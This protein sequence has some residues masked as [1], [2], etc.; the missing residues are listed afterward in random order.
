[1]SDG[2]ITGSPEEAPEG[3][4]GQVRPRLPGFRPRACPHRNSCTSSRSIRS[5]W[6]CRTRSCSAPRPIS[7]TPGI[8]TCDLY[9]FAPVG[10]LTVDASGRIEDANLTSA[11]LLGIDRGK[12]RG[13]RFAALV[14]PESVAAWGRLLSE[15]RGDDEPRSCDLAVRRGGGPV[16]AAQVS[17]QRRGADPVAGSMRV[18][19]TDISR[20]KRAE[21]ALRDGEERMRSIVTSMAEGV[22]VQ[23]S[24]GRVLTCNPA[25]ERILGLSSAQIE[26]RTS[27]D[28][29]WRAIHEDGSPF[30]G[31]EHPA[32]RTLSNGVPLANVLMGVHRP[33]G[34]LVWISISSEPLRAGPG[35]P[36]YAVVTT[37][38]D[39]TESRRNSTQ[40]REIKERL[41]FVIDGSNDGFWDWDIPSGRVKYS[42]RW[43]TMLG[44][45][46]GELEPHVST[47]ERLVHPDDLPRALAGIAAHH[48][49]ETDLYECEQRVLHK[50]GRWV[51]VLDRGK[52][53]ERDGSGGADPDGRDAHRR[54]GAE[55]G[56]GGSAG[57]RGP[58]P[59]PRQRDRHRDL[60]DRGPGRDPVR[61]LDLP[62]ADRPVRG[63]GAR[64][65]RERAIHP[66]D[67]ER[68]LRDWHQAVSAGSPYR[69]EYRHR[70]PDGTVNWVRMFGTPFRDGAGAIAGYVGA[71]VDITEPRALQAQLA[72]A[73]RLAA[74]GT[75]VTGVAH[76]INNPLAAEL[77]DQGLALEVV[78]EVRSRLDDEAPLDRKAEVRLLG[79]VVEA[80]EDAQGSGQRIARIVKDLTAFGRPGSQRS[81][82][83]LVDVVN[84]ALRWVPAAAARTA[85]IQVENGGAPDVLASS[86]QIEQVLL[87][88]ITNAVFATPRGAAGHDRRSHR[89]RGARNGPAGRDRPR[90]GHR[91]RE[92]GSDLRP[93][94]HH[95]PGRRREGNGARPRHQPC[96][97]H[98]PRRDDRRQQ[99]GGAGHHHPGGAPLDVGEAP[100]TRGC[101][102]WP[103]PGR[104]PLEIQAP[105]WRAARHRSCTM[106]LATTRRSTP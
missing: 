23:E 60:P 29:A 4:R 8:A 25:A 5:S 70:L 26:G 9:D 40:L 44:Y 19:L 13:T 12:L 2:S 92:P 67:R 80:L 45:D 16:F 64:A 46:I 90:K 77:A 86:G 32:M 54:H 47:W 38:A 63:R 30:P 88:L 37:F 71:L 33:D 76:E 3:R 15:V 73:S 72:L 58:V 7:Q 20:R 42:R 1:M 22:V 105:G 65:R 43:A 94:L 89:P 75:L 59:P 35:V 98:L 57:E 66:D 102:R 79:T 14:E 50:D 95:A 53:V 93:L 31:T 84:G 101:G 82:V 18:V 85:T 69:G 61:E 81:A 96:H 34:S 17:C 83:R 49:G 78:R 39:V 56:R 68:V 41:S 55:G 62:G 27:T 10:Y 103:G 52:V 97:R 51:W 104:F 106:S 99:R 36:P 48:R 74:M 24:S 28:P 87:N 91:A 11:T 6:R 100:T 21:E